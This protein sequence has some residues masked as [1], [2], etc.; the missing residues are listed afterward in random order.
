MN[1]VEH[2]HPVNTPTPETARRIASLRPLASLAR[3]LQSIEADGNPGNPGYAEQYQ[4]VVAQLSDFLRNAE[5]DAF[6]YS[7]FQAYPAA[8][9]LYENLRYEHAGLCLHPLD[10]AVGSEEK[11]RKV[12]AE[13]KQA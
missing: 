10:S 5:A 3:I 11:M 2:P 13:F 7:I 4:R 12:L 9:E 1:P 8:G 6:L